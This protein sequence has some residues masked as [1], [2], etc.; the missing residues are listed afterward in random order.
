MECLMM[1]MMIEEDGEHGTRRSRKLQLSQ[2][3]VYLPQLPNF[4]QRVEISV[5]G[6][7]GEGF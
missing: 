4:A 7:F 6:S 3:F 1:M 2:L 5:E